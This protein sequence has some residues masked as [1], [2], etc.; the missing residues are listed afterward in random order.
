MCVYVCMCV[1]CDLCVCVF[2]YFCVSVCVCVCFVTCVCEVCFVTCVRVC[3]YIRCLLC[4][5]RGEG[6][7]IWCSARIFYPATDIKA[8]ILPVE[9][10]CI[11]YSLSSNGELF[12][13]L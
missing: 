12:S 5:C 11:I 7:K 9:K 10:R 2:C 4:V 8:D 6:L 3:Q 13:L 1:F